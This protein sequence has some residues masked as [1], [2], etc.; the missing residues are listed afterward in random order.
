MVAILAAV[1]FVLM[2]VIGGDRGVKSFIALI[3][4]TLII[5]AGIYLICYGINP[6]LIMVVSSLLFSAVTLFYINEV[7]LKTFSSFFA[8]IIV[9]FLLS[10][11]ITYISYHAHIAGY[12]E[13]DLFEETSM[14]LSTDLQL[15]LYQ[16]VICGTI[17]GLL[18][19]IVDTSISVSS[20]INEI[21]TNR[22]DLG[23]KELFKSGMVIGKDILGT[24]V[25]T[26]LFVT[27]G[28]SIM[29][30][31]YYYKAQYSLETLLNAKSFIQE[32][33]A[34]LISCMGCTLIIPITA[35][36]FLF[37]LKSEKITS[38]FMRH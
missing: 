28:E 23:T 8:V 21:A 25:N 15:N 33:A 18:G 31:L 32:I 38:Y 6:I 26:L 34:V 24:M 5:I 14:Y 27:M 30:A 2:C 10:L 17:W 3:I 13:I 1:L 7:T 19:A 11:L 20:S 12:S 22:S 4:N 35:V 9:V 36:I 16:L 37:F 29:L